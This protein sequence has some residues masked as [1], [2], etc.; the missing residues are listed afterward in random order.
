MTRGVR[1]PSRRSRALIE[2][3]STTRAWPAS[4]LSR[5]VLAIGALLLCCTAALAVPRDRVMAHASLLAS[6]PGEDV[7]VALPPQRVTLTFAEPVEARLSSIEVTTVDGTRVDQADLSLGDGGR[8]AAVSLRPLEGGTYIVAWKNVSTVDGHPLSGRFAFH[9]EARSSDV[10][11]SSAPPTFP[12]RLEPPARFTLDGGLL[13]LAGTLSVL[14]F[15][16][17]RGDGPVSSEAALQGLAFVAAAFALFGA[18]L[19]LIAQASATGATPV[20]LLQG[21]WGAAYLTRGAAVAAAGGLVALRRPRLALLASAVALGSLPVTSHGA[22]VQGLEV[23]AML[24]D[25][26]HIAAV[27]VWVGA[28][29]A[30]LLLVWSQRGGRGVPAEALRRFSTLALIAAGAAGLSGA[31]LAWL[32]VMRLSAL[33]STYGWAVLAKVVLFA[34]LLVLG[35]VHRRWSIPRIAR[36]A[37]HRLRL[38]LGVEAAF[39]VGLVVAVAVM[40]STLPARES[41]RAPL[42]GGVV[43]TGDGSTVDIRVKPALPGT[44][45]VTVTVR[46]RRGQA[47]EGAAVAVRAAPAGQAADIAAPAQSEGRGVYTTSLVFGARGIWGVDASVATAAGFDQNASVRAEIGGAPLPRPAPSVSLG[48][49]GAGWVLVVGGA[50]A[51]AVADREWP[52]RARRRSPWYGASVAAAG[53]VV[54]LLVAPRLGLPERIPDATPETLARGQAIYEANC[55]TCH[56][57]NFV[58]A[59]QGAADLRAHVPVHGDVYLLEV[60]RHGRPGTAMPPFRETLSD[61][62]IGAV[63]AYV[64]EHATRL[65]VSSASAS[66]L[67]RSTR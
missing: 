57:A 35:L 37:R 2:G 18:A 41:L 30:M 15:V 56:G 55:A 51:A 60:V 12:S 6:D 28:L 40:T 53:L 65:A 66:P 47:V 38:T 20:D 64:K 13:V 10:V 16:L 24:I 7:V 27:A 21:R 34:A 54:L 50:F 44:N 45:Q 62:E 29:P 67:P 22:A 23:P 43:T 48:W 25:A 19:Q 33:D 36:G 58:P 31:Y 59:Q 3:V 1:K 14:A 4:G 61:D 8:R 63:L 11:V 17:R 39:G 26:V 49:K 52:W 5:G 9:V 32:H 42:P 46:D